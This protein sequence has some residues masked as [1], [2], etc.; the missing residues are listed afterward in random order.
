MRVFWYNGALQILPESNREGQLLS[1]LVA[2]LK[3]GRPPEMSVNVPGGGDA[4][5][6]EE[7]YNR[8][9]ADHKT[10]PRSA[11]NGHNKK[12]VVS[13]DKLL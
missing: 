13:I 10:V 3:F 8:L 2:Q 5:G 6:G 1:E 11:T 12:H 9:V 4:S 7:L